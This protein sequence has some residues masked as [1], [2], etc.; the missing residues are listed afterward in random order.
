MNEEERIKKFCR[1]YAMAQL[2]L[3]YAIGNPLMRLPAL[4]MAR[5][6]MANAYALFPAIVKARIG[7]L[8]EHAA[9]KRRAV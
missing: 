7:H 5:E 9:A 4:N 6:E 8:Y 3:D 2:M 1:G